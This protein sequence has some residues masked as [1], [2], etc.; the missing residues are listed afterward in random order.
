MKTWFCPQIY[1]EDQKEKVFTELKADFARNWQTQDIL[2]R[3]N[4]V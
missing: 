4:D 1:G 3:Q 2:L